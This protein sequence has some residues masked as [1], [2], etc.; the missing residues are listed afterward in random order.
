M[1]TKY[2]VSSSL[3]KI[4]IV[5]KYPKGYSDQRY[6]VD[7]YVVHFTNYSS[8]RYEQR[9]ESVAHCSFDGKNRLNKMLRL[10]ALEWSECESYGDA[11]EKCQSH[12]EYVCERCEF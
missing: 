7:V 9:I 11:L 6:T 3:S 8:A 1:A 4:A 12:Y 5:D 2:L 10:F